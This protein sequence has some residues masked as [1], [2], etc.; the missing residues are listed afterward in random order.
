MEI[1]QFS[2]KYPVG[3]YIKKNLDLR[4]WSRKSS[5][6]HW[7]PLHFHLVWNYNTWARSNPSIFTKTFLICY[8]MIF[9]FETINPL[10]KKKST[11]RF[12]IMEQIFERI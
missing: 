10:R 2:S 11:E 6:I 3:T 7:D 1:Y 4:K 12:H 5:Y 9:P 8:L